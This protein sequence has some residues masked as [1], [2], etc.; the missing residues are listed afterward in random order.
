MRQAVEL[1]LSTEDGD[2]GRVEQC[3]TATTTHDD[4]SIF[5]KL[6]LRFCFH[7]DLA[8]V[9]HVDRLTND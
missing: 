7:L 1:I 4:C 5:W 3:P 8:K 9:N 2:K 6:D